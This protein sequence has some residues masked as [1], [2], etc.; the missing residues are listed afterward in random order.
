MYASM[1]ISPYQTNL[2]VLL[3]SK[4]PIKIEID[5]T[6]QIDSHQTSWCEPL[7]FLVFKI[8]LVLKILLYNILS[9]LITYT[10]VIDACHKYIHL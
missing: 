5:Q 8:N 10:W 1:L 9:C 4:R 2:F 3:A 6:K 7:I